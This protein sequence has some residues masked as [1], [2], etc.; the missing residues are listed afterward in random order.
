MYLYELHM[1]TSET[2]RCGRS[3]AYEMVKAYKDHGFTGVVISDHFV[4]GYSY[5]SDPETWKEKMDVFLKGYHAAKKAGEELGIDVFL[6]WEYT[7][8]GN[9]AFDLVTLGLDEDFLYNVAVDCDKWT[10]EEYAKTVHAHGGILVRAHPY[11]EAFYFKAD[12]PILVE[13]IYDAVEVYNGGNPYGTDFDDKALQYAQEKGYPMVAGSDT[14]HVSTTKVGCVGFDQKPK[15]Y[16][17]L[18]QFILD[19]KAHVLRFKKPGQ[20]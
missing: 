1:H 5:S 17:E 6:A 15:D 3:T 12:V 2:S 4:N 13:N 14:H 8:Q 7:Y 9:N 18:C 19:K 11:R 20:E 16:K 10:L